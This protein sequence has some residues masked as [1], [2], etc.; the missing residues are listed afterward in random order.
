MK[1]PLEDGTELYIHIS[2]TP[3]GICRTLFP[4]EN[5]VRSNI[6]KELTSLRVITA[7]RY[8]DLNILKNFLKYR[9]SF[10]IDPISRLRNT[11][12]MLLSELQMQFGMLELQDMYN[13]FG[14]KHCIDFLN[15]ALS[16]YN[17][18]QHVTFNPYTQPPSHEIA[19]EFLSLA[20]NSTKN[21]FTC[22]DL[23]TIRKFLKM[24][25]VAYDAAGVPSRYPPGASDVYLHCKER[26]L[27]FQGNFENFMQKDWDSPDVFQSFLWGIYHSEEL[28]FGGAC[29]SVYQSQKTGD[30]YGYFFNKSW[31]RSI[32]HQAILSYI[33]LCKAGYPL[34]CDNPHEMLRRAGYTK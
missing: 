6:E 7:S 34:I 9:I 8:I 30:W 29:I 24:C 2:C 17:T 1:M 28:R 13:T 11:E 21:T 31:D 16:F 14:E 3:E 25:W 33:A 15:G 4:S 32:A 5:A 18:R 20:K 23:L 26:M 22:T 27:S 10:S 12:N 19:E